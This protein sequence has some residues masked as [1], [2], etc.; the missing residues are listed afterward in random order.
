MKRVVVGKDTKRQFQ[1]SRTRHIGTNSDSAE[2]TTLSNLRQP[3]TGNV[4]HIKS[5]SWGGLICM[6][7]AGVSADTAPLDGND[8]PVIHHW[9]LRCSIA[10]CCDP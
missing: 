6:T 7:S 9:C 10:P 1:R 2:G 4:A 8:L 3:I 5:A